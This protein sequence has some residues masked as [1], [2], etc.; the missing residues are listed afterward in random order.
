MQHLYRADRPHDRGATVRLPDGTTISEA[1]LAT[2]YAAHVAAELE[3]RGARLLRNDPVRGIMVGHYSQ[4]TRTA[5]AWGAHVYLACHVNAGGG[6]YARAYGV[7]ARGL[8]LARE[9]V[10]ELDRVSA[11]IEDGQW[12]ELA[13]GAR[14]WVCIAGVA[15]PALGILLEPF[16]VD[17]PRHRGLASSVGLGVIG[18]AIARSLGAWW[19]RGAT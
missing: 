4:R 2:G 16:F 14:G 19:L 3:A 6:R 17:S 12:L 15:P 10:I 8:R 11:L 5:S 18:R 9:L 7:G 1:E 13:P